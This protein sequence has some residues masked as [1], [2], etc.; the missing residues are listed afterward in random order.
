MKKELA[1]GLVIE[2]L[3]DANFKVKLDDGRE[4]IAYLSGRMLINY[5]KVVV[6]DR[7]LVEI[8]SYDKNKG[9]IIKRL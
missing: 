4:I 8:S 6:G 7:V 5:I 9:R 2:S 1:E 3:P